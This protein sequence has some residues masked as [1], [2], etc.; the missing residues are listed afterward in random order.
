MDKLSLGVISDT[1][2][3][4]GAVKIKSSTSNQDIRY[5]KGNK[6][7]LYSDDSSLDVT[8]ESF[9]RSGIF[10]VVKFVEI[11]D[12]DTAINYKGFEVI[13]NK[14][15]NDLKEGYY[16]YDDLRGCNIVDEDNNILGIVKQVEEFPAQI[17]LRCEQKN[18]KEFFVPFIKEFII[19]VDIPSKTIFIKYMEGML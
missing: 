6:L 13:T 7:I 5:V 10:D 11:N 16:F 4:D 15:Q 9:H 3:V 1:F 18:H 19:K 17:T 2:G 12:I 8:V 14:D